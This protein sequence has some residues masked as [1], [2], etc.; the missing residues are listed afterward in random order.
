LKHLLPILSTYTLDFHIIFSLCSFFG[1]KYIALPI[2]LSILAFTMALGTVFGVALRW[3]Q[4][5]SELQRLQST[6]DSLK[7]QQSSPL[8]LAS[9]SKFVEN[10][11]AQAS[12]STGS[13]YIHWGKKT[14]GADS[15]LIYSG[16]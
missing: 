1:N 14:C 2:I 7:S 13:T 16:K 4:M 15:Q 3:N 8:S 10:K 11:R 9:T 6:I 5:N 12:I